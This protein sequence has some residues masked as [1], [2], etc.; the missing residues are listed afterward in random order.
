VTEYPPGEAQ[1]TLAAALT[2]EVAAR[3]PGLLRVGGI[4]L[5]QALEHSLF[6]VLRQEA[7]GSA[8]VP[9]RQTRSPNPAVPFVRIARSV[10]TA[11]AG[12]RSQRADAPIG[13]VLVLASASIHAR[14]AGLV[15]DEL[16]DRHGPAVH[17]L[18]TGPALE[19]S[20][21]FASSGVLGTHL[22]GRWPWRLARHAAAVQRRAARGTAGWIE[23]D[24]ERADALRRILV[25]TLPRLA[26]R[27]AELGSTVASLRP[28]LLVAFNESGIWGRLLPAVAR[29]RGLPS[30]DLPHGEAADPWATVGIGYD[31]VAVYGPRARAVMR[32]AGVD[33]ERIEE[34]GPLRFDPLI[35]AMAKV[36][37]TPLL[38]RRIV[39][40]SQP[41]GPGRAVPLSEKAR[42]LRVAISASRV[43]APC[44][45]LIRPHPTETDAVAAQVLAEAQLPNGVSVRIER[46]RDLHA[47]LSEAWVLMTPFSQS[48]YEAAI[49]GVPSITID[50]AGRPSPIPFAQEGIALGASDEPSAAATLTGLLD[51]AQRAEAVAHA[52]AALAPH[53]GTLDGHAADRIAGLVE[54]LLSLERSHA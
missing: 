11:F 36:P 37:V 17:L 42:I 38:P 48:V 32:A 15:A 24:A 9:I 28:S 13:G 34:V 18:A 40:A 10:R 31:L 35:R 20:G 30:L 41:A 6:T 52:R 33:D 25:A 22:D 21:R 5:A 46:D 4:D 45:M 50:L 7:S 8:A 43:A 26:L 19:V 49:A 12:A 1:R 3:T 44:E 29:A 47:L 14:L 23:L 53:L 51:D 16:R 39:F 2:A 27:A 54:R